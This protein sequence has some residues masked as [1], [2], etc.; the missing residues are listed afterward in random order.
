MIDAEFGM[1]DSS[2]MNMAPAQ[3]SGCE[4][5]YGKSI[6]NG[7]RFERSEHF[8]WPHRD[9]DEHVVDEREHCDVDAD[10]LAAEPLVQVLGHR[11]YL[12]DQSNQF[13]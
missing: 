6:D 1:L 8:E 11:E 2:L 3:R 4:N 9:F 7:L 13:V 5:I 12:S 10:A